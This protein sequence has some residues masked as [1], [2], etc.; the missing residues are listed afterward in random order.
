MI[1]RSFPSRFA[2]MLAAALAFSAGVPTHAENLPPLPRPRISG[3]TSAGAYS[4]LNLKFEYPH[5][6]PPPQKNWFL[7][8]AAQYWDCDP[9]RDERP[10]PIALDA[11]PWAGQTAHCR[12]EPYIS[13]TSANNTVGS[14]P[15]TYDG[16]K[17]MPGIY[18][19]RVRLEWETNSPTFVERPGPWSAWHRIFVG[20]RS[21]DNP[22]PPH[23]LAPS[24]LQVFAHRDITIRLAPTSRHV[25]RSP[26]EYYF[27][28]QRAPYHTPAD[29]AFADPHPKPGGFP[30][31]TG[32]YSMFK[33][34]LAPATVQNLDLG[35][36]PSSVQMKFANLSTGR[37]DTSFIYRFRV[38]ERLKMEK[39]LGPWSQWRSFI[40]TDPV[41]LRRMNT[42]VIMKRM[43]HP[44]MH[45]KH[46]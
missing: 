37:H 9:G 11:H 27:E 31:A 22:S 4:R 45:L 43:P 23:I 26:W 24:E 25:N 42:P 17:L 3:P 6:Q 19:V 44:T 1:E 29:N 32:Q 34:W 2:V 38:R 5:V 30:R 16:G 40:V 10:T 39:T 13:S 46:N 8:A 36:G 20:L 35:A 15:V 7:L 14:V 18:Y 12:L 33:P 41:L 21:E 28:W